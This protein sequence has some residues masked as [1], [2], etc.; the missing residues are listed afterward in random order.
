[1]RLTYKVSL[2]SMALASVL[3]SGCGGTGTDNPTIFGG[4][5]AVQW[6]KTL[7]SVE[8]KAKLGPPATSRAI[9]IVHTA[10]YDA[11]ACYDNI[12][13]G[14]MAGK[15]LRRPAA[16]RTTANKEKASSF[17]AY[18]A[19]LDL[20]P[21]QKAELD[22]K[23][24]F[25]GF[26]INDTTEDT[27]LPQG[28]GNKVARLL[29]DFRHTDGANQ[30]GDLHAGAYSDYTGYVPVNTATTVNDPAHWQPLT[31]SNGATPGYI[32]PH[33]GN[34]VPFGMSSGSAFR[35]SAPPAFGSPT[36]IAQIN[37]MLAYNDVMDDEKKVIAEYWADGPGSV[38]P[39]GHWMLF[40]QWVSDRDRHT[41][42]Q[43]IKMFFLLGNAVMDAGIACWDAKRTYDTS[44][45]I[46][47]IRDLMAGKQVYSFISPV[48]GFGMVDGSAWLPYQLPTFITP[49]FPEYTSGHSTFSAAGAEILKR[50]TGSDT[51]GYSVTV[52]AGSMTFE[53]NLPAAP[54]TLG[55][56][57]FS[58]AADQAGISRLIGGIHFSAANIE[59]KACGRKVGEAVWNRGMAFIN[60]TIGRE[61]P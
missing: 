21:S 60:G 13:S 35:P 41:L 9:A 18:R 48:A 33:W 42:D 5:L 15:T 53:P 45:P 61:N 7:L 58:D 59:G 3:L 38:L 40:G 11:W 29:I 49:P 4:N 20:F 1:M 16:E 8:S 44:R 23:M 27:S 6:D 55:W 14:T 25:L 50:W 36:Y 56:G 54:V 17:A 34:V 10:M 46:T 52:P 24:A 31:F 26:D 47:A 28:I 51:F 37:D 19:C 30:L 12:A 39:P 43:D 32:A 22:A 2:C 57:T